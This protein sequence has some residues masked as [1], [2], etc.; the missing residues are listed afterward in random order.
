M[1][2]AHPTS[3]AVIILL[4]SVD[5]FGHDYINVYNRH[6]KKKKRDE[7]QSQNRETVNM[8]SY[9]A[10]KLKSMGQNRSKVIMIYEIEDDEIQHK[11]MTLCQRLLV[12]GDQLKYA[13]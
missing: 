11:A 8:L 5:F 10:P 1:D 9:G 3:L 6:R 12:G 4:L 7:Q 2:A 13:C